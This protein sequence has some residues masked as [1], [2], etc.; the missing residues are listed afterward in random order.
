[1]KKTKTI[2]YALC[3]NLS[4]DIFSV[5][6]VLETRR[7]QVDHSLVGG[8]HDGRVG[9]L[10]DQLGGEAA[11]DALDALLLEDKTQ[12]LPEGG[13]LAALLAQPGARHLVRI[14]DAR[15]YR[16]GDGARHHEL[17]EVARV[18]GLG[19]ALPARHQFGLYGLVYHKV[20]YRFR[21]SHIGGGYTFIETSNT[22]KINKQLRTSQ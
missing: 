6:L 3:K 15:G 8:H 7:Q 2:D 13:V 14:G 9:Y 22:L 18:A 4:R 12:R 21:Y 17:E 20:D 19:V 10:A 16:L 1:M 5:E 11:V